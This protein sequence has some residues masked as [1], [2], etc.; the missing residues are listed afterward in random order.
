LT[1][2]FAKKGFRVHNIAI[3]GS[4]QQLDCPLGFQIL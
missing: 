2:P 4:A 3:V 1:P